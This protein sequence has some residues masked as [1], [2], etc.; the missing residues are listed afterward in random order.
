MNEK[1]TLPCSELSTLVEQIFSQ[2]LQTH[3]KILQQTSRGTKLTITAAKK[4]DFA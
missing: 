4:S 1:A 2:R 3:Q